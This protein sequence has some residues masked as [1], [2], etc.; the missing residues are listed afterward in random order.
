MNGDGCPDLAIANWDIW[1][2]QASLVYL[3]KGPDS[4]G[5]LHFQAL[6]P[7]NE[8]GASLGVAWGDADSDGDLDLRWA[9]AILAA[10]NLS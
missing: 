10:T 1:D 7:V 6:P 3:N 5:H 2:E 9:T 4:A 8:N